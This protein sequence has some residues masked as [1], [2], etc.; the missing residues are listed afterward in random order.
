MIQ[1]QGQSGDVAGRGA[2]IRVGQAGGILV[3]GVL[4]A[5]LARLPRHVAREIGLVA[6]QP[7]GQHGGGVI[8]RFGDDAED[9]IMHRH[10]IAGRQRQLAR[11]PVRRVVRNRQWLV[12]ADTA[13]VQRLKRQIECHHLGERGRIRLHVGVLLAQ[14]LPRLGIEQA[15]ATATC[16]CRAVAGPAPSNPTA[17]AA[18]SAARPKDHRRG[19]TA[20]KT[21]CCVDITSR[22]LRST[23]M[24]TQREVARDHSDQGR[25]KRQHCQRNGSR[26]VAVRRHCRSIAANAIQL[27]CGVTS[28]GKFF[29]C[30]RR[31]T[32]RSERCGDIAK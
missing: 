30:A 12:E 26:S 8:G 5:E 21:P 29:R 25:K 22:T 4:H 16:P 2:L 11:C 1:R 7:F 32:G 23:P 27:S 10:R 28:P 15:G 14:H 24:I 17:N 13:L 6:G 20:R 18:P 19:E 3:P 9:Q 31:R